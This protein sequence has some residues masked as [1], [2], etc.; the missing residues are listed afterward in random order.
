MMDLAQAF[1]SAF[2]T[3][4]AHPT[5][6]VLGSTD[7]DNNTNNTTEPVKEPVTSTAAVSPVASAPASASPQI[8]AIHVE[9]G[10]DDCHLLCM[11][12]LV[13]TISF[14]LSGRK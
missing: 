11:F 6:K 4:Y 8:Y 14:I 9:I 7:T 2:A 5:N 1:G 13:F 12:L 3:G 10:R